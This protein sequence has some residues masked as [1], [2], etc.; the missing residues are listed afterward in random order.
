M[1]FS[2]HQLKPFNS[3]ISDR[4]LSI[5]NRLWQMT[6]QGHFHLNSA[7]TDF[8]FQMQFWASIHALQIMTELNDNDVSKLSELLWRVETD[9]DSNFGFICNSLLSEVYADFLWVE[10]KFSMHSN[11]F[12]TGTNQNAEIF[13]LVGISIESW[14]LTR[15]HPCTLHTNRFTDWAISKVATV[16]WKGNTC[17]VFSDWLRPA[18]P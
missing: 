10:T 9:V 16:Q 5:H 18:H 14:T 6:F 15:W 3:F 8:L 1:F 12:E 11:V 4:V 7:F 2:M 17:N 13:G